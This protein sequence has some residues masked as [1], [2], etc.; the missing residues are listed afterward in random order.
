MTEL[1]EREERAGRRGVAEE[2]GKLPLTALGPLDNPE[3]LSE[4]N[5]SS[6]SSLACHYDVV[7]ALSQ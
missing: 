3:I 7:L 5:L 2:L 4:I 6:W 1:E